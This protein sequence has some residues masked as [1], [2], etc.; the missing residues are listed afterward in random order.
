MRATIFGLAIAF[1]LTGAAMAQPV[2]TPATPNAPGA[3]VPAPVP[4]ATGAVVAPSPG[5]TGT[6]PNVTIAPGP[7]GASTIQT[8]SATGGNASQPSR[9]VPQG[10][11][12]K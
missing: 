7:T 5:N 6:D 2:I 9:A 10:G 8:D 3:V 1:I 4:G 11:G 12:G